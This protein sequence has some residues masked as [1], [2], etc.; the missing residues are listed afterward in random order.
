MLV[1]R[2]V[3]IGVLSAAMFASAAAQGRKVDLRDAVGPLEQQAKPVTNE[4]PLPRRTSAPPATYPWEL[5]RIGG[6]GAL[7]LQVTIDKSGRVVE[8]RRLQGP[9]L[10][11]AI[12]SPTD[13]ATER[14]AADAIVNAAASAIGQWH[15][16]APE[17]PM[18]FPI[19]V[20]FV[21]GQVRYS[22]SEEPERLPSSLPPAQWAAAEGA[23]A[24]TRTLKKTKY[25]R[26]TYPPAAREK[27]VKGAVTLEVV[28]DTDGR[29]KD[30]RVLR[31]VPLLDQSAI[32]ATM[33]AR[34]EPPTVNGIPVTVISTVT[35]YFMTR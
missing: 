20:G 25:V 24:E 19:T 10:Q 2:A 12:G 29:V 4:N 27:G 28:I 31:S 15:F 3:M 18:T 35:H 8:V 1:T 22:V 23:I 26:P 16:S 7:T 5:R 13:A 14:A 9:V 17:A 6:R 30:A 34:Y 11:P 21:A 32:E 33:Q